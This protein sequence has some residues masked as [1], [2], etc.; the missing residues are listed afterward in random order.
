MSFTVV[1]FMDSA[2]AVV[3]STWLETTAQCSWTNVNVRK[4]VM[5]L[6]ALN[7]SWAKHPIRKVWHTTDNY[8]LADKKCLQYME[9]S[10]PET[11]D[12]TANNG[13]RVRRPPRTYSS[14][15]D[16]SPPQPRKQARTVVPCENPVDVPTP[17]SCVAASPSTHAPSRRTLEDSYIEEQT[18][19][20]AVE[21]MTHGEEE[22]ASGMAV[23]IK[24][25]HG[26]NEEAPI[27]NNR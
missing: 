9:N 20:Q 27:E 10:C 26:G 1:E 15:E 19:S 2:M 17:P 3:P 14:S 21:G 11:D 18:S 16:E 12:G 23:L 24:H 4:R 22:G 7:I 6:A 8:E 13:K 25:N 5:N